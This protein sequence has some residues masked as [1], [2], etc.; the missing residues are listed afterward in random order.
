MTQAV[1]T[2]DEVFGE[3]L[4]APYR[5]GGLGEPGTVL[6]SG[7]AAG[8]TPEPLESHLDRFGDL[9]LRPSDPDLWDEVAE[10]GLQGRGGGGFPLGAKLRAAASA[11]G[12]PLLVVN[13]SESE[14]ASA[15]DRTLCAHRPH[16]VLDG[17][18]VAAALVGSSEAAL[19]F[20]RSAARIAASVEL[21][22]AERRAAGLPDPRWH[23]SY[24][25]DRY[26]AGESSAVA[27][28]L[29]GGDAR[30]RFT[31]VP[32]AR[33]GPSGRPTVVS[34]VETMAHLRVIATLGS[35]AWRQAGSPDW[36]GSRL[37]TLAGFTCAPGAV[38]ELV[39]QATLGQILAESCRG[40]PPAAVLVGGFAG[41]W[42]D[43][44]TAWTTRFDRPDLETVGAHPGCG[45][46]GV[47]P[48]GACGV[49]ETA[50]LARYLADET[51]GQCG[52]CRNGLPAIADSVSRLATGGLG[53]RGVTRLRSTAD[54][55]DGG[56][57]CRHPDGVV[58]LVRSM[59]HVFEE[60]VARHA[61]GR[62][63]P[64]SRRPSVLPVP[65]PVGRAKEW[66]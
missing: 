66:R 24:G 45:L 23:L 59:L 33:G 65:H 31:P 44:E 11:P 58:R 3:R 41:T 7:P 16:L 64:G 14:P 18:A 4:R 60:D 2:H 54:E 10:S 49:A 46:L 12:E 37:L 48:S 39:G 29:S 13:A 8:A 27:S 52:P 17:A 50:G 28:F 5:L 15:K 26:V 30:P 20:H 36:P 42:L 51:A 63:C 34:N 6:L 56:G 19:H 55:V 1:A 35:T 40:G 57:V 32:L 43:A 38:L 47:L 21:A 61:A 22:I 53:A 9:P 62:P 25:P